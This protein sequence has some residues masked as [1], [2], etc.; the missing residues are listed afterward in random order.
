V[1]LRRTQY[2]WA[3]DSIKTADVARNIVI[4]K[5][6]NSRAVLSRSLRDYRDRIDQVAIERVINRYDQILEQLLTCS[7]VDQI[8][9][10]EGEAARLYFGVFDWLIVAQKEAFYLKGRNRRPP[11]D[12][13]NALLS[14]LYTLL[15]HDV[16]SALETVG[17]DPAV[18]FLHRDRP[19]RP[20]LALDL[21]EEFR[22]F[23]ADRL[24][25]TCVNRKQI[26]SD[27]FERSEAGAVVMKDETRKTIISAY[28]KRKMDEIEHPYLGE[29]VP[30]GLLMHV[31]AMLMARYLRGDIDEYPP[32]MWR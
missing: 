5:V 22:S 6:V 7:D 3:D 11:L 24:A 14:F 2:R 1:L 9:G 21:M 12:N 20:S 29:K 18:G 4:A 19:G 25:L 17:L 23:I 13:M 27:G 28:Q 8:R 16:G 32:Y 10:F 31:Q 30:I 26:Q 15:M